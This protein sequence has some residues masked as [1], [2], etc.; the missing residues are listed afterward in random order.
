MQEKNV[1]FIAEIAIFSALGLGLDFLA[2]I[3]SGYIWPQG[4]SISIALVP[5]IMMAY[6]WGI[7]GGLLTGLL[8]GSIQIIWAGSGAVNPFQ[9]LIDYILAYT[10]I[11]FA[12]IFAKRVRESKSRK[13]RLFYTNIG[14]LIF[15]VLRI[16][17]HVI[18]GVI[19]FLHPASN[20]LKDILSSVW[21]SSA[22][23]FGYMIPT[24]IVTMIITTVVIEKQPLLLQVEQ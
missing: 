2:G 11:G 4:G 17:L 21:A 19:F 13:F 14:I 8:I 9:V 7:K 6:R 24:I 18:S 5:I 15:G 23:N 10:V 1:R 16:I 12:G 22:Y 3:Y 20:D